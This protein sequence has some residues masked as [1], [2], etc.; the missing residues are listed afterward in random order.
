MVSEVQICNNALL[1]LKCNTITSLSDDGEEGVACNI[2]Y[3]QIRDAV[4]ASH[5]WNFAVEQTN[6]QQLED[7]PLFEFLYQYSLPNDCLRVLKATDSSGNTVAHKVKG[8]N[9]HS[10]SGEIYIEYIKKVTDTTTYSPLFVET[11]ATRLAA[12]LA[13]PL[14]ASETR[15]ESLMA[16]YKD[17]LKE[18]KTR[19]GQEGTPD[20]IQANAWI[21]SRI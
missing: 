6:L 18:A 20:R 19:D 12:S 2:L 11:L 8:R 17:I 1:K 15:S 3:P 5:P 9:L 14:T 16:A 10:D 7:T 4:L 21:D 13:Y